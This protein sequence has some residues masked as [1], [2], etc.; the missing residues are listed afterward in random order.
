MLLPEESLR[1]V[2]AADWSDSLELVLLGDNP[3]DDLDTSDV[4]LWDLLV[5][6]SLILLHVFLSAEKSD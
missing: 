2:Y 3:L 5:L 6:F 1:I 4:M